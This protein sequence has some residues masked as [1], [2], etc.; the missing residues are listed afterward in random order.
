MKKLFLFSVALL[1][2]LMVGATIHEV[3]PNSPQGSDNIRRTLR[4]DYAI[5]NNGDTLRLADGE[6]TESESITIDKAIT[7]IAAEGAKP[8]VKI[9]KWVIGADFEANGIEFTNLGTDYMLRTNANLAGTITLKNCYMHDSSTPFVYLSSNSLDNLVI[10]NCVFANN[11]RS[12]YGVVSAAGTITNFEMRNSTIS[13][14]TGTYAVL[15]KTLSKAVINHCTIYDCGKHPLLIGEGNYNADHEAP[16][17]VAV[18]NCVISNPTE[19]DGQAIASYGGTADNCVWNNTKENPRYLIKCTNV[20]K[21]DPQ[22]ADPANGDFNFEFTS[23]LFLAATDGTHIGDPRWGVEEPETAIEVPGT[24]PVMDAVLQGTKISKSEEGIKWNDNSANP[25]DNTASWVIDV[26]KAG[27]YEVVI[28]ETTSSGHKYIVSVADAE[29]WLGTI[30]ESADSWETGDIILGSLTF[31]QAGKYLL[32]LTNGTKNSSSNA[33]KVIVNYAGGSV[34]N[35]PGTLPIEDA[36][37]N[38]SRVSK[39]EGGLKWNN[40]SDDASSFVTWNV[41]VTKAGDYEVVVNENTGSGHNYSVTIENDQETLPDVGEG[42][43][44]WK[45]GDISLG[46]I[47][48]AN[49]GVY[50]VKLTNTTFSSESFTN[51]LSL[52]YIGGGIVD[53]PGILPAEDALLSGN[54]IRLENGSVEWPNKDDVNNHYVTW[55]IN[56]T[57]AGEVDVT[58]HVGTP[59]SGHCFTVGLYEGETL[60]ASISEDATAHSTGTLL[61]GS[62]TIP[63]AGSYTI[64]LNNTVQWSSAIVDS[65]KLSPA[66]APTVITIGD[67][68]KEVDFT[69]YEGQIVTVQL[70]RTFKANMY[71]PICLPFA[72]SSSALSNILKADKSYVLG[73]A[74]LEEQKLYVELEQGSGIYQGTPNMIKPS[75]DVVNPVFTNVEIKATSPDQTTKGV[76]RLQGS[77]ASHTIDNPQTALLVGANN[78]LFFPSDDT[79]Y[80]KSMRAYFILVGQAAGAPIKAA[81]FREPGNAPTEMIIVGGEAERQKGHRKVLVD[82]QIRIQHE[83]KCYSILGLER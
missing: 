48:I 26:A 52:N 47:S 35:L 30:S 14:I 53:V 60:K 46:I 76:L 7:F 67:N 66:V 8:K 4:G 11:T 49:T 21:A 44:V 34:V 9:N 22:F 39:A 65:I 81:C 64:R 19:V 15:V 59:S 31:E 51:S 50:T 29:G 27:I 78:T 18:S 71:N 5:I 2:S 83:G 61:L 68:D 55:N 37:I 45:S 69:A 41:N 12:E 63:A 57:A 58:L 6:Y 77:F 20:I 82:G 74:S 79:P 25:D 32:R 73:S 33:S 70:N 3:Y 1:T 75:E 13:N 24:L 23:P 16:I 17:D 40:S 62:I 80:I 54:I 28:N 56:A 42:T 36:I 38:G 43:N 10:D 72:L